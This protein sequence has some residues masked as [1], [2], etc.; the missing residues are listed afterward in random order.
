MLIGS[1]CRN[2][3]DQ[4]IKK[5]WHDHPV[6]NM[7]FWIFYLPG[8]GG[9]GFSNLLEHAENIFPADGNTDWKIHFNENK[10]VKFYG[11][12]WAEDPIPFRNYDISLN[13]PQLNS[14]YVSLVESGANTVIPTHYNYWSQISASPVK[15]LVEKDQIKIH[16]Y[17]TDYKRIINDS[18][19]KNRLTLTTMPSNSGLERL[20]QDQLKSKKYHIHIDIEKVWIDW[21]YLKS[22]LDVLDIKLDKCYYDEYLKIINKI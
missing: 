2:W 3:P 6:N 7:Q 15:S 13:L 10:I 1:G 14:T 22:S 17:S 4:K 5:N 8:T 9:D 19:V 20:I 11:A 12:K 21:E 16:L 18:I